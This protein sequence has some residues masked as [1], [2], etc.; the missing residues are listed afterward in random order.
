[1]SEVPETTKDEDPAPLVID[2]SKFKLAIVWDARRSNEA[3][4][5]TVKE[6]VF[7]KAPVSITEPSETVVAPE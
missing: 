1:M 4:D 5:A 2:P 6:V 3:F 7:D